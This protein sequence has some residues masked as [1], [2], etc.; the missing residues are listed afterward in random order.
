MDINKIQPIILKMRFNSMSG[1]FQFEFSQL[2][3]L[4]SD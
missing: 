2:N 3:D 1:V 4:L